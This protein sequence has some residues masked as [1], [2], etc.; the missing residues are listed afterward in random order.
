MGIIKQGI[1]GGFSNK[2]G[3]VVGSSWKGIAVMR[4]MPISVANP[5]T[6]KQVA[7]RQEFSQ[8]ARFA[9]SLLA[10]IVQPNWNRAAKRMSGYNSFIKVNEPFADPSNFLS[11]AQ[12][13]RL[14]VGELNLPNLN[15]SGSPLSGGRITWGKKDNEGR[16]DQP[17][18]VIVFVRADYE[19]RNGGAEWQGGFRTEIL[20]TA[21]RS[22]EVF[23]F[24]G[25]TPKFGEGVAFV[26]AVSISADGTRSSNDDFKVDENY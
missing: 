11:F 4:S 10:E 14:S 2:V 23:N 21:P 26:F 3:S 19:T 8:V 12:A 16:F 24:N 22:A 17:T 15:I 13:S 25:T 5:R 6:A 20:G 9:S 7:Q 18:D 1:L